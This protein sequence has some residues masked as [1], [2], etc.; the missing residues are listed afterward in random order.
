MTTPVSFTRRGFLAAAAAGTAAAWIASHARELEAV[1]ALGESGD[2]WLVLTPA[3]AATLDA[4]TAQIIPTDDLP[5]AREAKVVRFIDRSFATVF[6]DDYP[7]LAPMLQQLAD[8]TAQT[9]PGATDFAALPDAQQVQVLQAFEKA[10][11]ES[12]EAFRMMTVLGMCAN[13]SY[14]GNFEKSGWKMVGFVDQFA[15][16]PPFG[17][18]D[19]G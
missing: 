13:P 1:A 19:R 12:F 15:W 7:Q 4:V 14:G 11:K 18:Y 10:Q 6:K 17:W 16:T 9:V 5:G 3:Q 2:K 8:V